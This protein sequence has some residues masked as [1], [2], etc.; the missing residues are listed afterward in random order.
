MSALFSKY[1]FPDDP[2][3]QYTIL[4][5]LTDFCGRSVFNYTEADDR[6]PFVWDFYHSFFFSFTVSST[7]GYGNLAPNSTLGRMIMIFYA[8]FGMPV[9]GIL[10]TQLSNYFGRTFTKLYKKYKAHKSAT[11][12]N[13]EVLR[14]GLAGQVLLYL[15]PG[16]TFFIFIPACLFVLFEDWDYDIA[17]YY[18]FVTLTTIGFGDYVAGMQDKG[19]GAYFVM[20]KIFLIFWMT[21]GLGYILM[22]MGF[23]LR[24]LKSKRLARLEHKLANNLKITQERIWNGVTRDVGYLRRI[25][26][27][28]YLVN[29]KPVYKDNLSIAMLAHGRS[30]SCPDLTMYSEPCSLPCRRR[31]N[32]ESQYSDLD[33]VL[34]DLVR[35]Q[36]DSELD[37]VDKNRTFGH[38]GSIVQPSELLACVVGALGDLAER[39]ESAGIHGFDDEDILASERTD[40]LW[41]MEPKIQRNRAASEYRIR[42]QRPE[43][44]DPCNEWTWSGPAANAKLKEL[45]QLRN[46]GRGSISF[47]IPEKKV[48]PQVPPEP[49][50]KN[51]LSRLNPFKS[52][53]GSCIPAITDAEAGGFDAVKYI[54][55]TQ[56][57]RPSLFSL[58]PDEGKRSLLEETSIADLLRALNTLHEQDGNFE[59]KRKLG[60]ASMTPPEM[61]M[62]PRPRRF[63]LRPAGFITAPTTSTSRRPSVGL[64]PLQ[65]RRN[66]LLPPPPYIED[67]WSR[68]PRRYSVRLDEPI[69][70]SERRASSRFEDSLLRTTGR[71]SMRFEDLLERSP[72]RSSIRFDDPLERT[73]RRS[74]IR[75]DQPLERSSRRSSIRFDEPLDRTSRRASIRLEEPAFNRSTKRFSVRLAPEVRRSSLRQTPSPFIAARLEGRRSSLRPSTQ[76]T[77]PVQRSLN[78]R[79]RL[80]STNDE[81][82][83]E[84]KE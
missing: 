50:T 82:T 40:S 22:C 32:S 39:E 38:R 35:V 9:H 66:S 52:R 2:S 61:P 45:L 60:T 25:L 58:P 55:N 46:S 34:P 72:R 62:Q 84:K 33:T 17:V 12:S 70:R 64:S 31:A 13:Y 48:A 30:Q 29:F 80:K 21:F 5:K 15:I 26:N 78:A 63:S 8:L 79:L 77:G 81:D 19:Y 59:P 37:R 14:L 27:E 73:A 51:L 16:V 4:S 49:P 7:V 42:V 76:I 24:G 68:T 18:A 11:N 1:N 69:M 44:V 53:R 36:S 41:S 10:L 54:Q 65:V 57:G 83:S 71:S 3:A 23:I 75:F 6:A 28:L 67:P 74:S 47:P 56:K 20:Y 43:Y